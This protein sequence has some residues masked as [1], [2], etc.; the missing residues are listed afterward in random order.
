[1]RL[2]KSV[3]KGDNRLLSGMAGLSS[4]LSVSQSINQSEN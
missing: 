3:F 1:M 4:I 2:K